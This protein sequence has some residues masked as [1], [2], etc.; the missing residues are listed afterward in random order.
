MWD[1]TYSGKLGHK[2]G[3]TKK[4]GKSSVKGNTY[5][6]LPLI[7]PNLGHLETYTPK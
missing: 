5:G 1:R 3:V 4:G 2:F 7:F 6:F